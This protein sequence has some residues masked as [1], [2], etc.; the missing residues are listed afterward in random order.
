MLGYEDIETLVSAVS[1]IPQ[2]WEE[3]IQKVNDPQMSD[4]LQLL[5]KFV[6]ITMIS[7]L[8]VGCGFFYLL[9][10]PGYAGSCGKAGALLVEDFA[11]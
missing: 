6:I 9:P 7:F 4:L 3:A 1:V 8:F 10:W 5:C 11:S 2:R